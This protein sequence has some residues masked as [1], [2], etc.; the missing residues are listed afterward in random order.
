MLKYHPDQV[1]TQTDSSSS[2]TPLF[3]AITKPWVIPICNVVHSQTVLAKIVRSTLTRGKES[4]A[5]A[6]A[7]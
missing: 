7:L 1:M 5:P 3:Q 2:H 4:I 6:I